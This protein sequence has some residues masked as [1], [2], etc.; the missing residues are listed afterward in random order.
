[1]SIP[2]PIIR[3]A[4]ADNV[5]LTKPLDWSRRRGNVVALNV[6]DSGGHFAATESPEVLL[7]DIRGFW[8]DAELSNTGVFRARKVR[9]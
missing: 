5:L 4:H 3:D 8:G 7:R 2:G 9:A 6:H 1:M